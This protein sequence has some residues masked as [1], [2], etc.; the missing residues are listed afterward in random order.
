MKMASKSPHLEALRPFSD[1]T[2][3]PDEITVTDPRHPLFG[4][5]F[6]VVSA[7]ASSG[8]GTQICVAYAGG[9]VLKLSIAATSLNLARSNLPVAKLTLEAIR[10]LIRLVTEGEQPCPSNPA[11]S[12]SA[13][14]Q[15]SGASSSMTSP[16]SCR[17]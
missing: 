3:P 6:A 14:P 1:S 13:S 2:E 7:R 11:M 5:R 12:G 10:E 4:R 15:T 16:P 8:I 17:R 9:A